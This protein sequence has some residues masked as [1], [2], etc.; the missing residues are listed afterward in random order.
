[1]SAQPF[2]SLELFR[3]LYQHGNLQARRH[4]Y[5]K[6][7]RI[8]GWMN[9]VMGILGAGYLV[10]IGVMIAVGL[11]DENMEPYDYVN[12]V[13]PFFFLVDYVIRNGMR[14][15]ATQ[16]MEPY[17]LLPIKRKRLL[18]MLLLR[19]VLDWFN[20]IWLFF[21]I[22]FALISVWPYWGLWGV[23][24]YIAGI[25][26]LTIANALWFQVTDAL[27]KRS[28][29]FIL[30]PAGFYL[31][32]FVLYFVLDGIPIQDMFMDFGD[33]M[34]QGKALTFLMLAAFTVIMFLACRY[35]MGIL[36]QRDIEPR[37][38][39]K[40]RSLKAF[41]FLSR[42]GQIG[43]YLLLEVRLYSRNKTPRRAIRTIVP[44][45]LVFT[46]TLTTTDVFKDFMATFILSYNFMIV[47]MMALSSIMSYEGNYID[48]LMIRKESIRSLLLAKYVFSALVTLI[49]LLFFIPIM[50]LMKGI[51]LTCFSMFL[52]TI[53]AGAFMFMQLAVYNDY[54]IPLSSDLTTQKNMAKQTNLLITLLALAVPLILKS[55]L[56]R[57]LDWPWGDIVLGIIG[58]G[59]ILT[60]QK[61]IGNIYHRLMTR[62]YK[63]MEGMRTTRM[64]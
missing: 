58:A 18:D 57:F 6:K 60:H 47:S 30:I 41:T 5:F 15:E 17:L 31:S 19:S 39:E 29:W 33:G 32:L 7:S 64:G 14:K 43:E 8:A 38:K 16:L 2:T 59:F 9:V 53:G 13:L 54:T 49:P 10:F 51:W 46:I 4:P 36:C 55:V 26:L 3:F 61:W 62:R 35:V 56:D 63:N 40:V 12:G 50:I 27:F 28:V 22:P 48:C 25:Y 42:W 44:I 20:L 45:I 37:S 11:K 52:F 23:L 34:I 24:T 21:F 1:M